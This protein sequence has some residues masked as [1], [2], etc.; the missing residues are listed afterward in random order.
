[1]MHT[2]K[3]NS[4]VLIVPN[5]TQNVALCRIAVATFAAQLDFSVAEI[6]EIK[7]VVSEAVTNA[8]LH[9]YDGPGEIRVEATCGERHIEVRVIDS[10]KG[11]DDLPKAREASYTTVPGRMGLGFSFM[12]SLTDE[13]Q[14]HTSRE[15]GTI[16]S[17]KKR[18]C[19]VQ[20]DKGALRSEEGKL[21]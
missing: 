14:V 8:V 3:G 12:E 7:V 4:M 19:D 11:I 15:K 16:I 2:L 21:Q 9:A 18:V 6:E 17:F 20:A 5:L 1:M 10:G 13:L